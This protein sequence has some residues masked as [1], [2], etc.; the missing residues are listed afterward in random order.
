[1]EEK[2]E[3]K[4]GPQ[5]I[6]RRSSKVMF[7]DVKH[8]GIYACSVRHLQNVINDLMPY[9]YIDTKENFTLKIREFKKDMALK[10]DIRRWQ[11]GTG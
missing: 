5:I 2:S 3:S 4:H 6:V 9:L 1:M 7:L 11:G 8:P 10:K